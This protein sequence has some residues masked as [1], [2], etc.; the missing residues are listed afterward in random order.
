MIPDWVSV[1][2]QPSSLEVSSLREL[3]LLNPDAI[4]GRNRGRRIWTETNKSSSV[5]ENSGGW[6]ACHHCSGTEGCVAL[7]PQVPPNSINER[8][9][10]AHPAGALQQVAGDTLAELCLHGENW[11]QQ[12]R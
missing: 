8:Q 5:S 11:A 3:C 6:W 1:T 10:E 2:G 4:K 7:G 9:M 12:N